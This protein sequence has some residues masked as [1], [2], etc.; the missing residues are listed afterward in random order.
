[1]TGEEAIQ[2]FCD[3]YH[4][5]HAISVGRRSTQRNA[6]REFLAHSGVEPAQLEAEHL[7]SYLGTLVGT[8]KPST[9]SVRHN[10][11]S[12]FLTWLWQKKVINAETLMEMREVKPPRGRNANRRPKPYTRKELAVFWRELDESY[13]MPENPEK[14]LRRWKAGL[15]PWSRVK[16]LAERVQIEAII[17]LALGGGMRRTEIYELPAE[18]IA[19]DQAYIVVNGARK[20]ADGESIARPVPWT[21][22]WMHQAVAAWYELRELLDPPHDRAWLSLANTRYATTPMRRRRF[23]LLLS[24][25]G[26]GW[27]LHRLRHT[28]A[29]ELLRSGME[30]EKVQKLLGHARLQQTLEYAELLPGDIVLSAKRVASDF[31]RAIRPDPPKEE[32][33]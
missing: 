2:R 7:R 10:C 1:M 12:P 8:L 11:V 31:N 24:K 3:E 6:L 27:K 14:W 13:P 22:E 20:N 4:D 21:S 9:I 23:E 28:C 32:A 33:A 18:A 16:P 19:P 29:T 15:S 17:A 5:Y 30:L 25:M 26:R